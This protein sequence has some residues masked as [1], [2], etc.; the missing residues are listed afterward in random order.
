MN[1]TYKKLMKQYGGSIPFSEFNRVK[2]KSKR[3]KKKTIRRKKRTSRRVYKK[4]KNK[5]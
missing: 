2:K 3:K 5:I 4:T 1:Q